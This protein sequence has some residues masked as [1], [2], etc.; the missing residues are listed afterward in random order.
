[1][2]L[3]LRKQFFNLHN[4]SYAYRIYIITPN[5][6]MSQLLSYFSGPNTSGAK[7]YKLFVVLLKQLVFVNSPT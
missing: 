5:D 3:A 7:N 4:M 2:R 6:H 1:M